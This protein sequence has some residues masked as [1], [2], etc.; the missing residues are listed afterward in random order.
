MSET[1]LEVKNLRVGFELH[2]GSVIGVRQAS[3]DLKKRETLAIV[4][5]SGSGKSVTA[6]AIMQIAKPGR[7]LGGEVIYQGADGP[8]DIAGLDEHSEAIRAIRG[9]RIAMVFQ[10][11]MSSLSP[12]HKVGDQIEEAITLHRQVSKQDARRMTLEMLSRV[13]LPEPDVTIDKYTFQLS[14]GQ[15]Q[16]VMIAMA[17]V[18][19]PDILIADEPTTA[20]DVTT[21]AEILRL[22][23]SLQDEFGMSV[24]F[25][26]HDMGVVAE[27][28]DRVAVMY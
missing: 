2:D 16:R 25:I 23:K 11:P 26:T 6:K 8:I 3:F 1:V 18:C 12:V 15:R 5:E 19:A 24:I 14:G 22:I 20:L 9:D 27:I 28:A 7:I 13:Q 10:E 21:Q 4:G 17:L